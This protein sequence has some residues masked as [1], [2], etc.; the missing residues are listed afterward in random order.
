MPETDALPFN[1][2]KQITALINVWINAS[3]PHAGTIFPR[4]S[5]LAGAVG[6]CFHESTNQ[7]NHESTT[8]IK[9]IF[10]FECSGK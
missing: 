8:Q 5:G 1:V 3:L 10:F 2:S 4:D 9:V 7:C 6:Q